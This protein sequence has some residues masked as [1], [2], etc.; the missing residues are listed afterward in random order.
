MKDRK[1]GGGSSG[2]LAP[3][4]NFTSALSSQISIRKIRA[5]G[6]VGRKGVVGWRGKGQPARIGFRGRV[7]GASF[8]R[9]VSV[10]QT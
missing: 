4:L 9:H 1:G 3:F 5:G 8:G 6:R 2:F 7:R 10:R